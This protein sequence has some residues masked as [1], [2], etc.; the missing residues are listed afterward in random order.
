MRARDVNNDIH[1]CT[2]VE[3]S[4]TTF[5]GFLLAPDQVPGG[6]GASCRMIRFMCE[7]FLA[8]FRRHFG[9]ILKFF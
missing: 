2:N 5:G 6:S 1:E 4:M 8:D 7:A 3:A 9:E